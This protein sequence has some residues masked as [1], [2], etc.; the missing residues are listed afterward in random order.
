MVAEHLLDEDE[1]VELAQEL[2][3]GLVRKAY[4]LQGT[5]IRE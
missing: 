5:G 2:T 1:A 3:V 4:K